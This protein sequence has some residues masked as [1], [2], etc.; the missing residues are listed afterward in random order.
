MYSDPGPQYTALHDSL[1]ITRST[2]LY[3]RMV[4]LDL[5]LCRGFIQRPVTFEHSFIVWGRIVGTMS[6]GRRGLGDA[7]A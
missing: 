5:I 2:W 1:P 6:A 4:K 3:L 7:G